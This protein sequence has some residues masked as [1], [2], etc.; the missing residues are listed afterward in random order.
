MK[1]T[2]N[3][4]DIAKFHK[5]LKKEVPHDQI[6]KIM[7]VERETLKKFSPERVAK[8]KAV[9]KEAQIAANENRKKTQEMATAAMQAARSAMNG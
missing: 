3:T 6:V 8:A 7:G 4:R 2:M 9:Q 5:L 1:S